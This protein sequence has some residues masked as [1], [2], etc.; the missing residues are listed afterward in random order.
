M[1]KK[2]F[3]IKVCVCGGGG[4]GGGGAKPG[5][6]TSTYLLT[7]LLYWGILQNVHTLD[8]Q[9]CTH[10]HLC[11]LTHIHIYMLLNV[12]TPIHSCTHT[13]MHACTCMCTHTFTT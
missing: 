9:A 5:S 8:M 4:G 12:H 1:G 3:N 10:A 2:L 11:M 13:C 6:P 7:N